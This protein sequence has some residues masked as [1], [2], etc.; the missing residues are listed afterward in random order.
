MDSIRSLSKIAEIGIVSGSDIDYIREQLNHLITKTE[1]RFKLHLLPCNGTKYYKP[2]AYSDDEHKLVHEVDMKTYLG[3]DD[4][5]HLMRIL[6]SLQAHISELAIPLSG[7]FIQYRGSMANWCPIGRR[8]SSDERKQFI[9]YDA[10]HNVRKDYLKRLVRKLSLYGMDKKITCSLGGETSFDIYP[11]GWD[12]TYALKHFK[13][14]KVWFV[15]D[16]CENGGN[17]QAIYNKLS[18]VS[19]SFKTKGTIN[20]QLIIDEQLIPTINQTGKNND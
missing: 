6:N 1:I 10:K 16:R 4:F 12:K 5:Y 3:E 14:K 17:D 8:A 20:T 15:G 19:R 13:N 2:P 7:N 11:N 18:S 9:D